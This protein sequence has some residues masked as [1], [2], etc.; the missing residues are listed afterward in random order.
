[1][2]RLSCLH[3]GRRFRRLKFLLTLGL[4]SATVFPFAIAFGQMSKHRYITIH[5]RQYAYDPPIIRANIGDTLHIKLV[6][7]DVT[8]GF[9]LEG[10]DID[11]E[12]EPENPVFRVRN[13]S[14]GYNWRS[15]SEIVINVQKSGKFRYRCSHTCGFLHP[16]M[17][18][19]LVVSPNYLYWV[20]VFLAIGIAFW[21][22][23]QAI[24]VGEVRSD[25]DRSEG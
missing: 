6:S 24:P 25:D 21:L 7:K 4:F 12:I 14:Q 11:A 18:G 3:T 15:V 1:M 5:A 16:F 9:Y 20:G 8:H 10:H 17:Q 2:K 22:L 23:W 13:P 19:E